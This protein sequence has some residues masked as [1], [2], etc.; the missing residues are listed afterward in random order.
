MSFFLREQCLS[1][2]VSVLLQIKE[3]QQ[4]IFLFNKM[5]TTGANNIFPSINKQKANHCAFVVQ[6]LKTT[7]S[8]RQKLSGQLPPSNLRPFLIRQYH[9]WFF[10]VCSMQLHPS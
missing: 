10:H 5:T 7:V 4:S 9:R 6:K 1:T 8:E 3:L 2:Q